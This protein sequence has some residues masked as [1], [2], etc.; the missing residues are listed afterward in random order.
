MPRSNSVVNNANKPGTTA[1][2]VG[3]VA[4]PLEPQ[5]VDYL[6]FD[7]GLKV[8]PALKRVEL[9]AQLIGGQ[10]RPLEFF[11]V[12]AGGATHESLFA[13]A[14]GAE[15]LKR[16]LELIG[17]KEGHIK[18]QGRGYFD[19]PVGDRVKI[20]VR[21]KHAGTGETMVVR[22]EEWL[23]DTITGK[24]PEN[25]G[26]VFSGGQEEFAP[27]QNR[28]TVSADQLGNYIAVWHDSS[29]I[30]DN[31]RKHGS[32]SDCYTPNPDAPGMPA[33]GADITLIFEAH[34]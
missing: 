11:L 26:F 6:A 32:I 25:V 34:P 21:F 9:A 14:A 17:L 2:D 24:A 30:L 10:S 18:R 4:I 29:C 1:A 33:A 27:E 8:Y 19:D 15:H 20:S 22:A 31:D 5:N 28:Q 12:A 16:A 23:I 3:K 13:T 7:G